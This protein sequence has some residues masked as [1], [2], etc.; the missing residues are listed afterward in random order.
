MIDQSTHEIYFLSIECVECSECV[1]SEDEDEI[2]PQTL[3]QNDE[4]YIQK[5]LSKKDRAC[6]SM[7]KRYGQGV[8]FRVQFG[9]IL[10]NLYE[11]DEKSRRTEQKRLREKKR[12]LIS[13]RKDEW[14]IE[15]LRIQVGRILQTLHENVEEFKQKLL[16]EN[17]RACNNMEKEDEQDEMSE[18]SLFQWDPVSDHD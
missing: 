5:I 12:A 1:E 11:N 18:V 16:R 4:E 9:R 8:V 3:Y 2:I 10:Q 17:E 7:R 14:E 6:L 15:V 13:M